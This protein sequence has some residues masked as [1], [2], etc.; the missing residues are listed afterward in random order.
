MRTFVMQCSY[1]TKAIKTRYEPT[2]LIYVYSPFVS[3]QLFKFSVYQNLTKINFAVYHSTC[4]ELSYKA[5]YEV[6]KFIGV[7][8]FVRDLFFSKILAVFAIQFRNVFFFKY[9]HWREQTKSSRIHK[10]HKNP[11]F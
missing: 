9:L 10:F 2:V 1:P 4:L 3:Q 6:F 7:T 5:A 8:K 11:P